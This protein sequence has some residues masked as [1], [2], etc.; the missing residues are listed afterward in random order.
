MLPNIAKYATYGWTF[1]R[2]GYN[3]SKYGFKTEEEAFDDLLGFCR[4]IPQARLLPE[5]KQYKDSSRG[6]GRPTND[7][8]FWCE[9]MDGILSAAA[10]KVLDSYWKHSY[11]DVD[12]L[13][14]H[15]WYASLRHLK[16]SESVVK[17]GY[18]HA[19]RSMWNFINNM[20]YDKMRPESEN[21][22]WITQ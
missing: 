20:R 4:G 18:F 14:S 7:D 17:Y 10:R 2:F 19:I 21:V 6:K 15:A 13:K 22:E 12:E 11:T 9:E 5:V 3:E 8:C 16:N 1:R